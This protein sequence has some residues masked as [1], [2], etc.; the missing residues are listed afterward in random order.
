MKPLPVLL[1]S[2][3]LAGLGAVVGS[4]LGNAFGRVGL[5]AG[6][7]VGGGL[8]IA[9]AV[10]LL[11]RL[12]WLPPA[13][14]SGAIAGGLLGF[15]IAVPIAV[16]NLH[17]PI[18]PI[19]SCALVGAGVLLGAGVVRGSAR[20]ITTLLTLFSGAW[21]GC[22]EPDSTRVAEAGPCALSAEDV[23]W[24]QTM[25]VEHERQIETSD[26]EAMAEVLDDAIVLMA[27]NQVD[28]VGKI[29]VREWQ[30]AWEALTFK[31][32]RQT[33]ETIAGCGDLAYVK[34]SYSMS[35]A[36]LGAA[37]R[38]SDSGRRVH[39]LRRRADGTWAITHDFFSSDRPVP[40]E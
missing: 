3:A 4:I 31:T 9:G 27:P 37:D 17:T 16:S 25:E 19:V 10:T 40:A 13:T 28:F 18:T 23:A 6:A 7:V 21:V 30:K 5:F 34:M 38:I 15:L 33:V 36:P 39:I 11:A 26:F 2:W 1:T 24:I 35:F 14:R 20:G 8:A 22:S 29:Q 32:Y 12:R